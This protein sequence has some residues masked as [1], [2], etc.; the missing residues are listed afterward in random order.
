MNKQTNETR[1]TYVTPELR[2]RTV[3]TERLFLASVTIP[4][5]NETEEE[6]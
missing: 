6:W 4:E 1:Q 5:Y 3:S 2:I